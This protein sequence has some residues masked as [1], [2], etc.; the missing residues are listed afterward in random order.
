[1]G[2]MRHSEG[3]ARILGSCASA[4]RVWFSLGLIALSSSVPSEAREDWVQDSPTHW[5]ASS[6]EYVLG[7]QDKLRVKV[8]AWRP[9]RDEIYEW[10]ALNDV[11][12]VGASGEISLPLIG[13][14]PASGSRLSEVSRVIGEKLK[15]TLGLI[16]APLA[17]IEVVECRP[18]YI[19]GAVEKPGEYAFRP[20]LTIIQALSIAGGLARH[21]GFE[22]LRL[23]RDT[24]ATN[25]DRSIN[26][27]EIISLQA[28]RARL[29][30]EVNG[31]R[32][33]KWP[34]N[35]A[36]AGPD[37]VKEEQR[38]FG[39]RLHSFDA[40]SLELERAKQ[41]L[42]A[43]IRSLEEHLGAQKQH[44]RT[45]TEIFSRFDDLLAKK[46]T[47]SIRHA[48]AARS[49]WQT[50][51][52]QVQLQTSLAGVR[53]ELDRVAREALALRESRSNE[54]AIDLRATN[55]R[56]EELDRR[57]RTA[58]TLALQASAAMSQLAELETGLRTSPPLY[59][60]IRIVEGVSMSITAAETTLLQPGDTVKVE[61]SGGAPISDRNPE[62]PAGPSSSI[63]PHPSAALTLDALR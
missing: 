30:A 28:R 49:L 12:T 34:D 58:T 29:E 8:F 38:I 47:T 59:T 37:I 6:S 55:A 32:T 19:L 11:Y 14:V 44:V 33:V 22:L 26:E 36:G 16:E 56:L 46:L 48:D 41:K 42:V 51:A 57:I 15:L 54:A 31:D 24:I 60:I 7:P 61:T 53:Q 43:Q 5:P 50:Q 39:M 35:V 63:P 2:A 1:M 4:L 27:A 17:S 13:D 18:F 62:R 21:K 52:D 9:S 3:C 25:G 45:A 23:D 40:R 20:G 10:K